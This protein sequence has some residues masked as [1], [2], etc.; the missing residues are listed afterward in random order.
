MWRD[1]AEGLAQAQNLLVMFIAHLMILIMIAVLLMLNPYCILGPN[2][3][4]SWEPI[5]VKVFEGLDKNLEFYCTC[6]S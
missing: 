1:L 6:A 5:Q 2:E 3:Q 4:S